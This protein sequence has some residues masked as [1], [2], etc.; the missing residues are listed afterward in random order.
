M[1][2]RLWTSDEIAIATNGVTSRPFAASGVSIDTRTVEPG[3]LFI[4]LA[5]ARD[6]HEFVAQALAKG[7][8]GALVS[9]PIE[10]PCIQVADTFLALE[11]LGSLLA[12]ARAARDGVPS[13]DRSARPV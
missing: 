4:A 7:A 1:A 5:G 3:D 10:G 9:H 13:R 11:A 6:G 8:A 2:D 12:A